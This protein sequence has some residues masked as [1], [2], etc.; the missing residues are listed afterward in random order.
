MNYKE[1]VLERISYL[2]EERAWASAY[3]YL[4]LKAEDKL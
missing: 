4:K 1:E 3:L 2:S